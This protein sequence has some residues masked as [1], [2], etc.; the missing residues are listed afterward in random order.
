MAEKT[1]Q[2]NYNRGEVGFG[3]EIILFL[4]IIFIIWVLMGG[5]RKTQ[6]QDKP[7]IR[8]VNQVNPIGPQN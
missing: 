7:F 5:G 4:V 2:K 1:K 8:P 6:N 3:A